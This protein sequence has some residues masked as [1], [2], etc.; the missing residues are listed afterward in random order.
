MNGSVD[1]PYDYEPR[2]R[3]LLASAGR[4]VGEKSDL[5]R[6]VIFVT[7]QDRERDKGMLGQGFGGGVGCS[8]TQ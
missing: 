3:F 8:S 7:N 4:R 1:P 5:W 6:Q 2:D